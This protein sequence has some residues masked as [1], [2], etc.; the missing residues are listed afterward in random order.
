MRDSPPSLARIR[1]SQQRIAGIA[2]RTPL[3]HSDAFS[4]MA[5]CEVYLKAEYQQVTGSFKI[6]GALNKMA[7]L[8]AKQRRNGVVAASMGNH[9]QGVAFAAGH[10]QIPATIVMP[11]NAP[12]SKYKATQGYGATVLLHG[13]SLE[14]CVAEAQRIERDTGAYF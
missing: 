10:F 12:L 6:R 2:R 4:A 3:L 8:S 7:S 1:R 9:A 5:G 14:D 11:V 13:D